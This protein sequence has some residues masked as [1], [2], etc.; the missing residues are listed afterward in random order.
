MRNY[1]NTSSIFIRQNYNF[2]E[3]VAELAMLLGIMGYY[4]EQDSREQR[5]SIISHAK[6]F[7][8]LHQNTNWDNEDFVLIIDKFANDIYLKW[9]DEVLTDYT[10]E[11]G[12]KE[13]KSIREWKNKIEKEK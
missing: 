2:L 1:R 10:S 11:F 6:T 9:A 8:E 12:E 5:A 3:V 7:C 13:L 4:P